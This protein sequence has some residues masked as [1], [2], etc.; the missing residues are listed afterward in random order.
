MKHIFHVVSLAILVAALVGCAST[1]EQEPPMTEQQRQQLEAQQ[2]A[3][4]EYVRANWSKLR[5]GMTIDEVEAAIG[6]LDP[7]W[8]KDVMATPSLGSRLGMKSPR[9]ATYH[10]ATYTLQFD[11]GKLSVW[12]LKK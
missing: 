5:Q 2:R 9:V 3:Q 7:E 12:T 10:A 6:P 11:A 8:K 4:A 1:E